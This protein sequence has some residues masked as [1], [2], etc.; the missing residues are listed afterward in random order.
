M[1][2]IVGTLAVVLAVLVIYAGSA[3]LSVLGLVSAVRSGDV[4]QVM[5]QTDL[6]RVRH[7]LVHQLM[8]AYLERLG[9]KRPLRP[10]ERAAIASL[11]T[12]I[13]DDFATKLVTPENLSVLLSSGIV[14]NAAENI[15][16]GTM[17]SLADLDASN[18]FVLLGRIS[19]VKPVEF[20]LGLGRGENAGSVSMHFAGTGWKLSGLGLPRRIVA[21]MVDRLPTH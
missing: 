12:T 17:S 19:P 7:S 21:T 10:I 20:A 5:T 3:L 18:M 15:S 6:P 4:S 11:G 9:Q 8:P 2:W 16:F 1:K 14:R 13:A